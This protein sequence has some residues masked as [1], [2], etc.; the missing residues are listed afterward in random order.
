VP[1]VHSPASHQSFD[2]LA[3]HVEKTAKSWILMIVSLKVFCANHKTEESE[4]P[5]NM[6]NR[7]RTMVLDRALDS[8]HWA[9]MGFAALF[10][11]SII[12]DCGFCRASC[13]YGYF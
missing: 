2:F 6:S 9:L 4:N 12:T 3:D 8:T 1:L 10:T 5:V 13:R 11:D 7:D